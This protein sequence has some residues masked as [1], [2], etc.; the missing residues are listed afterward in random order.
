MFTPKQKDYDLCLKIVKE[1]I[2]DPNNRLCS[3]IVER[4][5]SVTYS[6]GGGFNKKTLQKVC[7]TV[8]NEIIDD[9][10]DKHII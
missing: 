3:L 5:L 6:I 9:F 10:Y 7:E 8:I 1:I 2:N 4:A